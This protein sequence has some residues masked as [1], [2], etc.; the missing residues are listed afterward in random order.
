[1]NLNKKNDQIYFK[2]ESVTLGQCLNIQ[3]YA[4]KTDIHF[5]HHVRDLQIETVEDRMSWLGQNRRIKTMVI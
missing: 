2:I 3:T 4:D 5:A 1:M